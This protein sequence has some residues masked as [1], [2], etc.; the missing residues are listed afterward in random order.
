MENKNL[1]RVVSSALFTI[2][3]PIP[4][5][6]TVILQR[7][8]S[9]VSGTEADI[10]IRFGWR[11]IG[12]TLDVARDLGMDTECH[13]PV[14]KRRNAS[15]NGGKAQYYTVSYFSAYSGEGGGRVVKASELEDAKRDIDRRGYR[16]R[17]SAATLTQY[18]AYRELLMTR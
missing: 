5:A 2:H 13:C 15:I 4:R 8:D 1:E 11:R 14:C 10:D 12:S 7:G 16:V 6:E 17:V 9:Y 18:Q 3:H